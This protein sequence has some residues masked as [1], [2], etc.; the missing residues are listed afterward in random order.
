MSRLRVTIVSG[1][2]LEP[3]WMPTEPGHYHVHVWRGGP[4]YEVTAL[5]AEDVPEE[6]S[7]QRQGV[8]FAT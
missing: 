7:G 8:T 6:D 3:R 2:E 5:V 4:A 1:P